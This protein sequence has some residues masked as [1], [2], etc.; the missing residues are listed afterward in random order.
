MILVLGIL[1]FALTGCSSG[2]SQEEY[3]NLL[4]ENMALKQQIKNY[5]S[6]QDKQVGETEQETALEETTTAE[7]TG[8][9]TSTET[10]SLNSAPA[11]ESDFL[12]VSN[13]KEVQINGYCGNGGHVII[14]NEIE[15]ASVTRIATN[16]FKDAESITSIVLPEKLQIVGYDAF[17]GLKNL[18]GILIIPETVTQ[19]EG[20]AFQSTRITGIVIKSS[21]EI[22]INAFANISSLEFIYVTKDCSP[23]IERS[24]FSYAEALTTVILPETVIEIE[25]ETFDGC[26]SAVFY[27]PDSSFSYKYAM[28]NFIQVD[29]D[30]Y[31]AKVTEFSG[32]YE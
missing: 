8:D 4:V 26:N 29:A 17:S 16:A 22:D 24:V 19:I 15:G 27:T 2:V 13:G 12:Y 14:P 5:E 21:C 10:E 3:D 9:I 23:K 25:D 28:R 7:T 1:V 11:P 18:S 30:S 6:Q 32:I 20:H 31:D